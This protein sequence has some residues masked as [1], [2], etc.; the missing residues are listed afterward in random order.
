ML[1]PLNVLRDELNEIDR[2]IVAL[3]EKRMNIATEVVKFKVENHKP[4]YDPERER[5][6][7]ENRVAL[8][9]NPRFAPYVT[10]LFEDLMD[11][12]KAE[13]QA[14]LDTLAPSDAMA[15]PDEGE[16]LPYETG[17]AV[18]HQGVP[19]AYS[20]QA[21]FHF[22]GED[23]LT[24]ACARFE[25]VFTAIADCRA[26]YGVL[27]VENSS[28]GTVAEVYDLLA[29]YGL[30]IV[31]E[32]YLHIEHCLLG[33]KGATLDQVQEVYSHKQGLLQCAPYLHEHGLTPCEM[34]NTALAAQ[35]V[36]ECQDSSKAAIAS[37]AAGKRYGLEVLA[38]PISMKRNN[39]TRFIIVAKEAFPTKR[40]DKISLAFTLS[41]ESG[42][43]YQALA[44]FSKR[45]L[46]LT[47]IES[48]PIPDK[49][50]E[51]LFYVD[52]EGNA[53]AK[54]VQEAISELSRQALDV[55]MLGNYPANK[56]GGM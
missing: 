15:A 31:G 48:R 51:Y 41:H 40:A 2:Q 33:V 38:Y 5:Q 21:L 27:P 7:I 44:H 16:T 28:T 23:A 47:R 26:V 10:A 37:R 30:S 11:M 39:D 6:V 43:L 49:N 12:S 34:S 53:A 1:R 18:A 36:A 13:Q 14:Y 4:I 46:N 42:S 17:M 3:F 20:E 45:A 24:I 25:D 56:Q 55:K 8:L 35:Y 19:G 29:K 9:A 22:F 54:E 52:F 32:Q 50:W